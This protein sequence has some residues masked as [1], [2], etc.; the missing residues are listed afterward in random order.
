MLEFIGNV[1]CFLLKPRSHQTAM[2]QRLYGILKTCHRAVGRREIRLKTSNLPIHTFGV[3]GVKQSTSS[4][5][6]IKVC[7]FKHNCLFIVHLYICSWTTCNKAYS[8]LHVCDQKL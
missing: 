2:P 6:I 5:V 1:I 4:S 7:F 8:H 3:T